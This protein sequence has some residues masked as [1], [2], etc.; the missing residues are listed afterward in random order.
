MKKKKQQP[1]SSLGQYLN[2]KE[3]GEKGKKDQN[4]TSGKKRKKSKK[5]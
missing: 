4:A 2:Q 5:D 3:P 1:K